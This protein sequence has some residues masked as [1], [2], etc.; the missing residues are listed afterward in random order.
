MN[1]LKDV[2]KHAHKWLLDHADARDKPIITMLELVRSKVMERIQKRYV[3]M[4]R[5][6]GIV[7]IKIKKILEKVVADLVGYI[8]IWNG[9][10]GFEVKAHAKQYTID[11]AK[12][13]CSCGSWQLSGIP[14]SH[15]IPYLL[16]LR[17]SVVAIVKECYKKDTF[18]NIYSNVLNPLNGMSLWDKE[19]ALPLQ[20]PP[21]VKLAD[22]PKKKRN[23]H[24]TEVKK[25]GK[26]EIL[27]K[28]VNANCGW[29][30]EPGHNVRS[31]PNKKAG[32][33][34]IHG[35]RT[36]YMSPRMASQPMPAQPRRPTRGRD[37]VL[38]GR[39]IAIK[40]RGAA[41]RDRG[42]ATRGRAKASSSAP[43][44][45]VESNDSD[46]NIVGVSYNPQIVQSS[47]REQR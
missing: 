4:S 1:K 12:N 17:K 41:T 44:P 45:T 34:P 36:K 30:R 20:P 19:N 2:D 40:G 3:A 43:A 46:L 26:K 37:I 10:Y 47:Q 24:I 9:K 11:V 5:K 7:C 21:H 42:A 13:W 39:R 32:N 38:R 18:L 16:H 22:R 31:F 8:I 27:I 33:D 14:C 28:W 29:C 35:C 15:S 23:R 6:P 25:R